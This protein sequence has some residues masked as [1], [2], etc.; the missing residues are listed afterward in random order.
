MVLRDAVLAYQTLI[1]FDPSRLGLPPD[2]VLKG[3]IDDATI[4]RLEFLPV[5]PFIAEPDRA[6]TPIAREIVA[7]DL[8][9]RAVMFADSHVTLVSDR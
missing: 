3:T 5:A 4:A 8:G 2:R 7:D 9:K 1:S 6:T